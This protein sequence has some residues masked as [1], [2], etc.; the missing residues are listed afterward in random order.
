M[1]T[2]LALVIATGSI[3]ISIGSILFRRSPSTLM[4]NRGLPAPSASL[5]SC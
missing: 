3:D 4:L 2:G 5:W 1:A